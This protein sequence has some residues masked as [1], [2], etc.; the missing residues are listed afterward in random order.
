MPASTILTNELLLRL[1]R[2]EIQIMRRK[3]ELVALPLHTVL[4]GAGKRIEYGY[5]INS[6]MASIL[7]VLKS[8]KMVEVGL[9][10]AEGFVGL[11]LV[12]GL[13]SSG[14]RVIVQAAGSA[15]RIT[16]REVGKAL[17]RCPVLERRLQ[18]YTHEVSAQATQIAACNR[19]H[20]SKQRLARWLLMSED[21]MKGES[22][23]LTQETL[24][25]MLGMRR[26]SVSVALGQLH[27]AGMVSSLRGRT[28][29]VDRARL[30]AA[31]CEC[32][33]AIN[34]G[35]RVWSRESR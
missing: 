17:G 32:Y 8:G 30:E 28:E 11:P 10:G 13:K 1:P 15:F 7:T 18:R 24:A 4:N 23:Q 2:K 26:A 33:S 25:R 3:L 16:A 29:I 6:G 35:R 34:E 9:S 12:A 31:S 21:R 14:G 19:L 22:V 20:N 5:F 27:K